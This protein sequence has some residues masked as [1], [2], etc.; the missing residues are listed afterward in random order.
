MAVK[1]LPPGGWEG[2][3]NILLIVGDSAAVRVS[4]SPILSLLLVFK[5]K[6]FS[7]AACHVKRGYFVRLV[8]ALS[9]R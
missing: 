9:S 2:T 8:V 3:Y 5:R 1:M 4:F 7:R 6:L